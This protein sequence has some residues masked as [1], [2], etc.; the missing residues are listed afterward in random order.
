MEDISTIGDFSSRKSNKIAAYSI[1]SNNVNDVKSVGSEKSNDSVSLSSKHKHNGE[2]PLPDVFNRFTLN[3]DPITANYM[4][5]SEVFYPKI[6][7][8]IELDNLLMVGFMDND[9]HTKDKRAADQLRGLLNVPDSS[10]IQPRVKKILVENTQNASSHL[11]TSPR[12]PN[13][14]PEGYA[15]QATI[16]K[17]SSMLNVEEHER[18]AELDK[19]FRQKKKKMIMDKKSN[20][21]LGM[22]AYLK[23]NKNIQRKRAIKDGLKKKVTV[24]DKNGDLLINLQRLNTVAAIIIQAYWRRFMGQSL[25]EKKKQ[26]YA[27]ATRIQAAARG[28][29]TRKLV[30]IW[31]AKR[32]QLAIQWQSRIRR[33]LSNLRWHQQSIIE[34]RAARNIQRVLRG[35]L[36]RAFWWRARLNRAANDIQ[37]LWRGQRGR[38]I[39]DKLWLDRVVT[40]IQCW[41]RR[42]M[43]IRKT[44]I[45]RAEMDMAAST[46]ARCYL[47][48]ESRKTRNNMLFE[49]ESLNRHDTVCLLTSEYE[50]TRE[51]VSLLQARTA[52]LKLDKKLDAAA[53]Q[54]P[55]RSAEISLLE[56]DFSNFV[57]QRDALTPRGIQQ[58]WDKQLNANIQEYREKLTQAKLSYIFDFSLKV[59]ELEEQLLN[60]EQAMNDMKVMADN[61]EIW[62]EEEVQAMFERLARRKFENSERIQKQA[63]ADERRKWQ[64]R[65]FTPS[66]KPDKRRRP[67]RAWDASVY[68]GPEHRVFCGGQTDIMTATNLEKEK[69]LRWQPE[70]SKDRIDHHLAKIQLQTHTNQIQHY[71]QMLEPVGKIL[72]KNGFAPFLQ[73]AEYYG[74]A[75]H[76][77][78]SN[79]PQPMLPPSQT[80]V[81]GPVTTRARRIYKHKHSPAVTK[82]RE[83]TALAKDV[84]RMKSAG[85]ALPPIDNNLVEEETEQTVE[86]LAIVPFSPLNTNLGRKSRIPDFQENYPQ[87]ST[88]K[89]AEHLG[90]RK[91]ST[92]KGVQNNNFTAHPK[93]PKTMPNEA[94]N[95]IKWELFDKIEAERYKFE[96]AKALRKAFRRYA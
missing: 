67:G 91:Q 84:A 46:I 20:K 18:L 96:A 32:S 86:A 65:W 30:A 80:P 89:S 69:K 71:D 52:R 58:G 6:D 38:G 82:L 49:R 16:N 79:I 70:G 39:A 9:Q 43:A 27:A 12:L 75:S 28:M 10:T 68:A 19:Q 34:Y 85:K 90:P 5:Y 1:K 15:Q 48:Y 77:K 31:W 23:E 66:G 62:R 57:L 8:K 59:R 4:P 22:A 45:Q 42:N 35:F 61:L 7:S 78:P 14:Q 76:E 41:I 51:E 64:L 72:Q 29:I 81:V 36:G 60:K 2:L 54:L 40:N 17:V 55:P 53:K 25:L 37:R 95:N 44:N 26:H 11:K 21:Q 88:S 56:F 13:R 83:A 92:S 87:I 24:A 93:Q 73:P 3:R 63:V 50:M 94:D 33:G 74:N 47:G